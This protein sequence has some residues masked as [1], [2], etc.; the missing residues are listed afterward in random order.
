[1]TRRSPEVVDGALGFQHHGDSR[2]ASYV[3]EALDILAD[4]VRALREERDRL[5]K[6]ACE[7]DYCC[8]K[9]RLCRI[10]EE[11]TGLGATIAR[12]EACVSSAE[13][14]PETWSFRDFVEWLRAALKGEP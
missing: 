1:M 2:D 8:H 4:E 10:H 14:R 6:T 12:V 5:H 7:Y 3:W 9:G 11:R 13:Q